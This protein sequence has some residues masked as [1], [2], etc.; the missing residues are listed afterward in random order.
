MFYL[1]SLK[2]LCVVSVKVNKL[3]GY[4]Y[5]EEIVHKLFH[6]DGDVIFDLAVALCMFTRSLIIKKRVKDVQLDVESYPKKLNITRPQK[7]F[8][9][10]SA[11]EPYTPSFDLQ[12]VV[13]E[14]L[15]NQKRLMRADELYKFSDRTLQKPRWDYDPGKLW[16]CSGFIVNMDESDLTMEKYIE[17]HAENVRRCGQTFNWET[18]TYGKIWQDYHL[19]LR[20]IYGS[21]TMLRGLTK[22]IGQ[23]LTDR[24]RMVYTGVEGH[25]LFTSD[26][27]RRLF[28]IRGSLVL[29]LGPERQHVA[30]VGALEDV[31]GAHAKDE[32]VQADL[33][34]VHASQPPPTIAQSRTMPSRMARLEEEV[35]G[36]R[37]SLDEQ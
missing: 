14:D 17:L 7:D 11:K 1:R 21:D 24:L 2:I 31:K 25:I 10:I 26:T 32:G 23:A 34:P 3:N 33:A 36:I 16:Y 6:L 9:T 8:P 22:E 15:S 29:T 20:G 27:W 5:L 37:V 13:Y 35:H 4:G 18:A 12:R 28:E 30:I 19:E